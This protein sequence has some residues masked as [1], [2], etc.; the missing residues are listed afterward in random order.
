MFQ[1]ARY[2]PPLN[3]VFTGNRQDPTC[4]VKAHACH[5]LINTN[6]YFPFYHFPSPT[7]IYPPHPEMVSMS[8]PVSFSF[9]M[10]L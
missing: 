2:P 4:T 6:T 5:I 3:E 7:H 9:R 1:K 8:P 10:V